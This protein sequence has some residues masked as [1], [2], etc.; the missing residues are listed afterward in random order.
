MIEPGDGH[1]FGLK[2]IAVGHRGMLAAEEHFHGDFPF[3]A[4]L[5][6]AIDHS[7]ASPTDF[8]QEFIIAEAGGEFERATGLFSRA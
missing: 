1:C 3:E 6:R 4:Q 2:A 7:H 5:P 8:L